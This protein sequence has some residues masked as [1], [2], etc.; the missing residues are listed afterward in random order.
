LRKRGRGILRRTRIKPR[1]HHKQAVVIVHM[2]PLSALGL[3]GNIVQFI[4]FR[5]KLV[6]KGRQIYK[7]SDRALDPHVDLEAITND[8]VQLSAQIEPS[9]FRNQE[10]DHQLK[11]E[12]V[13][14]KLTTACDDVALTLLTML[15]FLKVTERHRRWKSVRQALKTQ[16]NTENIEKPS[17]R[18]SG[19]REELI[20]H[21]IVSLE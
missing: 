8:L 9:K 12:A 20:L 17:R 6:C 18:F 10:S 11:E 19:F 2:G 1:F 13:L 14:L 16:W 7:S 3:A 4:N 15:N 5:S 21:V